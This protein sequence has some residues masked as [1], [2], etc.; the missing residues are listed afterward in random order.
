MDER[1]EPS[2]KTRTLRLEGSLTIERAAELKQILLDAMRGGEDLKIELEDVAD[3]D[4]TCLQLLCSAHRTSIKMKKQLMLADNKSELFKQA[5]QD[6][7]FVRTLGCPGDP[8]KTCL[9]TGG[10]KS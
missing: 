10:E 5:T 3:C 1:T 9:W 6:A 7:G 4:L 2:T 8:N